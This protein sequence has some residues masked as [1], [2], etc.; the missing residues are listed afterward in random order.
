MKL[1]SIILRSRQATTWIV[2]MLLLASFSFGSAVLADDD[3]QGEATVRVMTQNLFM[4]T[5]FPEL[6]AAR[7]PEEFFKAVTTTYNNVLDTMPAERMAAVALE[8]ARLQPD[9]IGLQEAAILR[10]GPTPPATNV[11][12]DMLQ[13]LL[14]ALDKSGQHYVAV[15][16]FSGLDAEAPSDRGFEVRFTVQDVILARTNRPAAVAQAL[17]RSRATLPDT[18]HISDCYRSHHESGWLGFRR[19]ARPWLEVPIRDDPPGDC[20]RF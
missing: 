8:I 3:G 20:A 17:E 19:C 18:A 2:V 1:A 9:L 13:I 4:G 16:I 15:A 11:V 10:T 7:T 12:F 5:D 6:V 14:D